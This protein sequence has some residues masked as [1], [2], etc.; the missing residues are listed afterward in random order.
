MLE[1]PEQAAFEAEYPLP[2]SFLAGPKGML[3]TFITTGCGKVCIHT[4]TF[5]TILQCLRC[6]Q[7]ACRLMGCMS[8]LLA[9]HAR[10]GARLL[11]QDLGLHPWTLEG[12]Q[13]TARGS[14]D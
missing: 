8:Q 12:L 14:V 4:L 7:S 13:K 1:G 2:G 6:C 9:C 5:E 10:E 3:A 11:R